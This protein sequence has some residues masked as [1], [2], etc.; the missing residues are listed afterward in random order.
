[1][2]TDSKINCDYY[3]FYTLQPLSPFGEVGGPCL[4]YNIWEYYLLFQPL[5]NEYN[6]D[7]QLNCQSQPWMWVNGLFTAG[8]LFC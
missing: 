8:P 5:Y 1:M 4:T 6:I 7:L 3:C 2:A